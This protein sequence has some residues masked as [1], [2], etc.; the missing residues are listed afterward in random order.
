M[1]ECFQSPQE[2]FVANYTQQ[3]Q[4]VTGKL[5]FST[6][7]I[8]SL[9]VTPTSNFTSFVLTPGVWSITYS[10][11]FGPLA[12][13][14]G[15][16]DSYLLINRNIWNSASSNVLPADFTAVNISQGNIVKSNTK[17][18]VSVEIKT[19]IDS[20]IVNY[21]SII[22]IRLNDIGYGS[23]VGPMSSRIIIFPFQKL[24]PICVKNTE[25]SF[26]LLRPGLWQV[27]YS[28]LAIN[29]GSNSEII[30]VNFLVNGKLFNSASQMIQEGIGETQWV[31]QTNIFSTTIPVTVSIISLTNSILFSHRT[32]NFLLL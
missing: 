19:T 25:N 11:S 23:F 3:E 15:T 20:V 24:N 10:F 26:T 17:F 22:F 1:C 31:T 13:V 14:Q 2:I 27:Q 5:V 12:L 21:A 16:L 29:Q 9:A 18:S 6:P 30:T 4:L 8:S 28:L 32:I 7:A